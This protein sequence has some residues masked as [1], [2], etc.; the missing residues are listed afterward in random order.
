MRVSRVVKANLEFVP[1]YGTGGSL[2][3]RPLLFGSGAQIG[4]APADEYH[5]SGAGDARGAVL[6]GRAEAR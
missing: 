1:P 6:Q 3:V 5:V 4:V 2:Y